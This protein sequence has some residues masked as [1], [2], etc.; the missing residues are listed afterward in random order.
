M[1]A[2]VTYGA[3]LIIQL[4]T[5]RQQSTP[6][7][8]GLYKHRAHNTQTSKQQRAQENIVRKYICS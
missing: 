6:E 2:I 1:I 7:E 5:L 4:Q 3:I 8:R